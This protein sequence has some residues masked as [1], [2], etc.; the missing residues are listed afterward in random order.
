MEYPR[1][2]LRFYGSL[3]HTL[4]Y[5]ETTL[6]EALASTARRTPD[7]VAYDFFG[8]EATY[9]ELIA[10]VERCAGSLAKLGL[11]KGDRLLVSMPT[12]PQ[13]V[14]AFYAAN[15]LGAVPAMVHPLS[16]PAE[17]AQYLATS[18]ARIALT[19]DAF[20][21]RFVG[22][23]VERL[24]LARI[25]DFLSPVKR[26]AFALTKGRKI[27]K[28]PPDP[29]VI[30]WNDFMADSAPVQ[31]PAGTGPDDLAAILFSGGTTGT[32]KGIV[33]SHRN[34]ISEGMQAAAWVGPRR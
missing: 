33:L 12:T 31:G 23:P 11:A 20:H 25:P 24:V 5:P 34:F 6:Y 27:P 8:T 1:P 15:R 17:I 28:V 32:P 16:A 7:A 13:A 3:P 4:E 21:D 26:M 19:L 10:M 29:R 22:L 2:W 30:W 14:I 18:R 9:R